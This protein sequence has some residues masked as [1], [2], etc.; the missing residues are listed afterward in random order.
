MRNNLIFF[1]YR[2]TLVSAV[3]RPWFRGKVEIIAV[4]TRRTYSNGNVYYTSKFT[5]LIL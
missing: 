2:G 5:K 3:V 1:L 4:S